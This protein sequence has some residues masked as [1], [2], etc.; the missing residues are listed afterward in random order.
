MT[1]GEIMG[2]LWNDF[3]EKDSNP[4]ENDNITIAKGK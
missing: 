1:E 4:F 2:E 3:V